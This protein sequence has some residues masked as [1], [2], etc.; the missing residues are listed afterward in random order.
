MQGGLF[1]EGSCGMEFP[2][3][4]AVEGPRG[5]ALREKGGEIYVQSRSHWA[6]SFGGCSIA[7]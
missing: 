5:E 7:E 4:L 2:E 3:D 1:G 6:R